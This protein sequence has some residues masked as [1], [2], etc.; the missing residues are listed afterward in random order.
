[1]RK[2]SE[3]DYFY[4][5]KDYCGIEKGGFG[6]INSQDDLEITNSEAPKPINH[7]N[8]NLFQPNFIRSGETGEKEL[9]LDE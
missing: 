4:Q 2:S 3:I 1:M 8:L 5:D 9:D 6:M 7:L